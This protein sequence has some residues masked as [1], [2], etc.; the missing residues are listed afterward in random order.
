MAWNAAVPTDDGLLIN[1]PG[2]IRA[3]WEAIA[4]GT[5]SSLLITNA[6]ISASAGI[7]DTKL[8]TISTAGK[9]SG[10][11]LTSLASIPAGAGTIPLTNIPGTLTNKSADQ[12]DGQEGVYYLALGNATGTLAIANGGT[13]QDT[14]QEAIDALLPAQSGN[15]GK[16]LITDGLNSSWGSI[17]SV[18]IFTSS[19]TFTAPT[20]VTKVYLTMIGAGGGGA[21]AGGSSRGGGGGAGQLVIDAPYT[22]IPGNN[23]TVTINAGGAGGAS[24]SNGVVGGTTVFDSLTMAGGN[25]GLAGGGGGGAAISPTATSATGGTQTI[26]SGGGFTGSGITGGGGGGSPFGAGANGGAPGSNAAANSGAGG[27]GGNESQA[28]GNGGSG[29]VIVRW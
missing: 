11:A 10:A 19:G 22:V 9:V 24:G 15:S 27:G 2:Q 18:Q 13:G 17:S 20:G 29:I 14:A 12:L 5:D 3:N 6:K 16:A 4:L 1:A 26:A 8:A 7:V 28:G 25:F 21:G 23:Y